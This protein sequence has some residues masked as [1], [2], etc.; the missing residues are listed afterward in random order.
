[1]FKVDPNRWQYRTTSKP[2]AAVRLIRKSRPSSDESLSRLHS[3]MMW[4]KAQGSKT[5][6]A[7][8]SHGT[9]SQ[10]PATATRQSNNGLFSVDRDRLDYG[11]TAKP[12]AALETERK[13]RR[14]RLEP[15]GQ[16]LI[17]ANLWADDS[18]S[19][20]EQNWIFARPGP[21]AMAKPTDVTLPP[22][23]YHHEPV[24]CHAGLGAARKEAAPMTPTPA[25]TTP[26]RPDSTATDSVI[27]PQIEA[28][29]QEKIVVQ[30]VV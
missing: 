13:L 8:M 28:L 1:M 11:G 24:S 25:D 26:S 3:S 22:S 15:A 14:D 7:E 30:P 12:P 18:T 4:S 16:Q 10:P 20:V 6:P 17:S 23:H 29:E 21:D 2:P 19:P 9:W 27:Q 5:R